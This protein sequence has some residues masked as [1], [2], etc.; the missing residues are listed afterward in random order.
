MRNF[1]EG[2]GRTRVLAEAYIEYV[3]GQKPAENAAH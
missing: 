3:A 2:Q 1:F